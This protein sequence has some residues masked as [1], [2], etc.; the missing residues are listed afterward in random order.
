M[1]HRGSGKSSFLQGVSSL[2]E[3]AIDLDVEIEKRAKKSIS[4]IFS[5]YGEESFRKLEVATFEQ[6]LKEVKASTSVIIV[7]GA[8]F[9][10][11]IWPRD[12]KCLWI[13]RET[14]ARPRFFLD[15][16]QVGTSNLDTFLQSYIERES[17]Y[18]SWADFAWTLPEE[19]ELKNTYKSNDW[20]LDQNFSEGACLTIVPRLHRHLVSSLELRKNMGLML[21]LRSDLWPEDHL[22]KALSLDGYKF[23]LSVRSPKFSYEKV[24]SDIKS[25]IMLDWDVSL[26]FPPRNLSPDICS[27]HNFNDGLNTAL[28]DLVEKS[29][30]FS[31]ALLKASPIISSFDELK[32]LYDWYLASP[33]TRMIFPRSK[34][35]DEEARWQWFRLLMK[36]KQKINFVREASE[37]LKDQPTL[38]QYKKHLP[39]QKFAAVLGDPILH[40]VSPHFHGDFFAAKN[41]SFVAI[42]IS[43]QQLEKENV[44]GFLERLGLRAAAVTSPLKENLELKKYSSYTEENSKDVFNTLVKVSSG[45]ERYNT[46]A[47]AIQKLLGNSLKSWRIWGSGAVARQC[48]EVLEN[49]EIY[50]SSEAK[51]LDSKGVVHPSSFNL[52]WAAGDQANEPPAFWMPT[53]LFD[54][55]YTR[56]SCAILYASKKKISYVNGV[57]FFRIQALAQQEIWKNL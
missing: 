54:L 22:I 45:W 57:E 48:F 10:G 24:F 2:F 9:N 39:A 26:E 17:R 19:L 18:Q 4:E 3:Y 21:E 53:E 56:G 12:Y 34:A 52:L 27:Q 47:Q 30:P 46:D 14:D 35:T 51:L 15:R 8:G 20:P 23:L 42:P 38:L 7:L 40:S 31:K 1:G 11:S 44:I 41:L 37:G 6:V 36:G 55:S 32:V 28:E 13:R 29:K 49:C 25:D 33:E 43:R 5:S 16:P 50:S